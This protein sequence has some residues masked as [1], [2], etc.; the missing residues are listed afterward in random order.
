[1]SDLLA[2]VESV[3]RPF[4]RGAGASLG[5]YW[6]LVVAIADIA[7]LWA[8]LRW[9]ERNRRRANPAEPTPR[10]LFLDLCAAHRLS[11]AERALLERAAARRRLEHPAVLFVV[12]SLLRD[13]AAVDA[14]NATAFARLEAKLFRGDELPAFLPDSR[15]Y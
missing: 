4:G 11:E 5:E 9:W 1:M 3:G 6:Y 14:A 12:P 2:A 10:S 7:L 8:G 15:P 13:A